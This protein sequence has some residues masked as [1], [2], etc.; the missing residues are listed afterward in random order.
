MTNCEYPEC[1]NSPA[2]SRKPLCTSHIYQL[3]RGGELRPLRPYI[4]STDFV[5]DGVYVPTPTAPSPK[6]SSCTVDSCNKP[7]GAGGFC[8]NHKVI[9]W[10][11]GIHPDELPAIYREGCALCGGR[12]GL[13]IDH[14]HLCCEE[15][16]ACGKCVRGALCNRCN[17]KVGVWE[18][19]PIQAHKMMLYIIANEHRKLRLSESVRQP[20][21][22]Y[23]APR[24]EKLMYPDELA[25]LTNLR[26]ADSHKSI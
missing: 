12:E 26:S 19:H 10:R 2:S 25:Y 18:N 16:P 22:P 9:A 15:A 17:M 21:S 20:R 23:A 6:R 11:M 5:Q 4:R 7:A 24:R 1:T 3:R 14:D 13:V 8:D